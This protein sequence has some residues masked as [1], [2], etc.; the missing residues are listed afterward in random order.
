MEVLAVKD[1]ILKDPKWG[2]RVSGN[3]GARDYQEML[4]HCTMDTVW[5]KTCSIQDAMLERCHV[6][7]ER[8]SE[9]YDEL[10]V[11]QRTKDADR[12]AGF[13]RIRQ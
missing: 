4:R 9:I 3:F 5:R 7:K 12:F 2:S 6:S 13:R 11:S 10:T 8:H 1:W